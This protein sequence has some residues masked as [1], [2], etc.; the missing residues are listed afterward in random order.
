MFL[1]FFR[2]NSDAVNREFLAR[3]NHSGTYHMIPSMV[4][5][6]YVIRFC[7]NYEYAT[8]EH[9]GNY[10][11]H[12]YYIKNKKISI[13]R[14]YFNRLDTAWED[15]KTFADYVIESQSPN[16]APLQPLQPISPIKKTKPKEKL[17]RTMSARFS[18]TRSVSREIFERQNS[19][20][21]LKDGCTPIILLDT[22]EI[23]KGLEKAATKNLLQRK[24][25]IDDST[26]EAS[27]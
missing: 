21:E 12:T 18:F 26:D 15:I 4:G 10:N 9:I 25:K 8:E 11:E 2:R 5:G 16:N 19:R 23:F 7:V 13:F 27:H 14:L 6:K 20:T 1:L 17:T 24:A 3:I 22:D